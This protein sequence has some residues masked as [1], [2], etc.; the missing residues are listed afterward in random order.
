MTENKKR[1]IEREGRVLTQNGYNKYLFTVVNSKVV[2]LI[3][4]N[5][6]SIQKEYNLRRHF[7]TQHPNLAE[8]D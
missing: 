8:L 5:V 7:E 6:V 4:R 3:C 1:N 2:C